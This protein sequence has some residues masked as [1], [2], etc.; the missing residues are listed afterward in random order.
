VPASF[1]R[2]VAPERLHVRVTRTLAL[3][4]LAAERDGQ[5]IP[6]PNEA[7]LCR[8]LGVSRTVLRE[9]IKVLAAKGMLEVRP[10]FG[11]HARPRSEWNL[12]DPDVLAWQSQLAPDPR[13]LRDICEVR[14]SIEPIAAG[15]AALRA[16]PK[17]IAEIEARLEDKE[18]A[19]DGAVE[20]AVDADLRFHAAVV[21]AAHNPL[22][23]Q[24]NA[25]TREPFRAA[26]SYTRNLRAAEAVGLHAHRALTEAI[27]RRDPLQARAA[28]EEIVG[29]AM[30]GVEEAIRAAKRRKPRHRL[31]NSHAL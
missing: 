13:I 12:L 14:L 3:R 22:L 27:R 16:G 21:A 1:A 30:V 8:Q 19:A 23:S 25:L 10:R 9:A 18:A 15:F 17:E 5:Q 29:L 11:T 2:I 4:I 6:F 28:A 20:D 31:E 24:L 26:L 7:D